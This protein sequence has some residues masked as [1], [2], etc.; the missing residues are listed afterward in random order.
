[1]FARGRAAYPYPHVAR[2]HKTFRGPPACSAAISSML[3]CR[4]T[5]GPNNSRTRWAEQSVS[6]FLSLPLISEFVYLSPQTSDGTQREVADFLITYGEPGLLVSQKCQE[7]PT[8]KTPEKERGWANK[9]AVAAAR[10]LRGA[11]RTGQNRL[12]WCEHARRGRV[13][14][15]EGLP[16]IA[17]GL[18][19]VET[20]R[21]VQLEGSDEELPLHYAGIPIH[22]FS[23]NDFLNIAMQLRTLPEIV[24]YLEQRQGLSAADRR[25]LGDEKALF[26]FYLLNHAS[27]DGCLGIGDAKIAIAAQADRLRAALR[28]KTTSDRYSGLLEHV[29]HELATRRPNYEVG[30]S[31]E[32]RH[33]VDAAEKRQNYLAMQRL[34]ASLRLRERAELGFAFDSTAQNLRE[35]GSG[36]AIRA[37]HLDSWPDWVF[38]FAASKKLDRAQVFSWLTPMMRAAMA[39]YEKKRGFIVLDRD[40]A[41]YQVGLFK[42]EFR[43]TVSDYAVGEEV[44]GK[45]RMEHRPL[46]FAGS[47]VP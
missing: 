23:L 45:L 33:A 44:F 25:V 20:F 15:A 19:L 42:E 32:V 41:E 29:A 30:L 7:D 27:F 24:H 39:H 31:P 3:K 6:D 38:V 1:M 37:C 40:G 35:S 43:P 11:L 28:E 4:M 36:F 26:S 22:Y 47:R 46:H 14:F 10:Q 8:T 17:H 34:L 16:R 21:P 18:V 13:E 5:G 2:T 9:N 12:M